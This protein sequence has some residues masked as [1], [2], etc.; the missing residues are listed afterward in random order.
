MDKATINAADK[1]R[2]RVNESIPQINEMARLLLTIVNQKSGDMGIK[3][4]SLAAAMAYL[5]MVERG[6]TAE[7]AVQGGA[8]AVEIMAHCIHSAD[9]PVVTSRGVGKA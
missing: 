9:E 6:L 7:Q 5:M 2:Q 3:L 4:H 1:L 8:I